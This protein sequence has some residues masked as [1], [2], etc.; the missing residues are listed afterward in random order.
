MYSEV[1]DYVV[2][3]VQR[4]VEL[5]FSKVSNASLAV[6]LGLSLFKAL[7]TN[8]NRYLA[9]FWNIFQGLECYCMVN[10]VCANS[11]NVPLHWLSSVVLDLAEWRIDYQCVY[12]L[13]NLEFSSILD[14]GL[15]ALPAKRLRS[16]GIQ[17]VCVP[18]SSDDQQHSIS[19]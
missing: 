3:V 7:S 2:V 18:C 16:V 13:S 19:R 1:V 15:N 6:R 5:L 9:V 8:D 10:L 17:F 12:R 11:I 14:G 4:V